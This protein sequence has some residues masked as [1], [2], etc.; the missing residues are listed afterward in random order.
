M[1]RLA[2]VPAL[3]ILF[4]TAAAVQPAAGQTPAFKSS[5]QLVPLNVTVVDGDQQFVRGLTAEDFT[6]LEDGVEQPV[7][8]F[9]AADVPRDLIVLVDTSSSMREKMPIVHKA[10]IGFLSTLRD[11]DRGAVV[12]FAD[13]VEVLQ[14][15]TSDRAALEAAVRSATAGG[16]TAL[17]DA[18]YIS[19]RQFGRLAQQEGEIR[20]Q[21]IAVLTDGED[22]SSLLDL[23][24]VV[25]TARKS[26]VSIYP[27]TLLSDDTAARLETQAERR[28]PVQMQSQFLLRQLARETGAQPFFSVQARALSDVYTTIAEE[29]SSQYSI[30]YAPTDTTPDGRFRRIAVHVRSRPELRLRTRTGYVVGSGTSM[31][32]AVPG[33][34][35]AFRSN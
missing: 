9:E 14:E 1:K 15:L 30:A 12:T 3:L 26:G 20:R 16:A 32:G 28:T 27:I 31:A 23:R 11:G 18:I 34:G 17:H 24:D 10:A 6:I 21:A 2:L 29:L 22:T 33:L 5:V 4:A 25:E 13:R 8:F 7:V 35:S 19:L